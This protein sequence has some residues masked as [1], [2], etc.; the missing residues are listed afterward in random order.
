[1][2]LHLYIA[3]KFAFA[4][5]SVGLAFLAILLLL[6]V[7]DEVRRYDIGAISFGQAFGLSTLNVPGSVYRILPLIVILATLMLYLGLART[8]EL[9]ITRASGRSALR[10]L[11]APVLTALAAGMLAVA[12]GNPIVAATSKRYESLS[13]RYKSGVSSV[14]SVSREGLWLRQ[15]GTEGQ[16]VIRAARAN[17]DGTT[18]Y[19]VTFLAFAANIGPAYRIEADSA[20]LRDGEWHIREAKRWIFGHGIENPERA[21]T[22]HEL[23][24]LPSDLTRDRIRDSF[25]TPAAIPIWDLPEFI[26]SLERAG[27]SA[28]QHRVWLHMELALPLTFVAMVMIGAGFTMRHT[29]FGRT[30]VMVL[31]ALGLGLALFFLRNFAQILGE[32]G[33]IPAELAAWSPPVIGILG[34]LGLLL[35]LEDG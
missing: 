8:S 29:R 30:G 12:V 34:A 13:S 26:D 22:V 15:G 20:E 24:T 33:Q 25:G 5:L 2:T 32:N 9:V 14:L 16:M 23:L 31:S 28:R 35:H 27:F 17:L 21:A 3:R 18:L 6:D 10:S 11:A 7:V 19:D 4:L 1:M